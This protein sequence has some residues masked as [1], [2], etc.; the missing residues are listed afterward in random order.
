M[1]NKVDEDHRHLR[2][3]QKGRVPD[4]ISPVVRCEMIS[5]GAADRSFDGVQGADVAGV[6]TLLEVGDSRVFSEVMTGHVGEPFF[7]CE[8]HH[9]GGLRAAGRNRHV[10]EDV[11]ALFGTGF[12]V[13][14]VA[15]VGRGDDD[16]FDIRVAR[17][18]F[19]AGRPSGAEFTGYLLSAFGDNVIHGYQ[20]QVRIRAD[21]PLV[22]SG[23]VAQTDE[24]EVHGC[25]RG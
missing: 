15:R 7:A 23:V 8:P 1:Q 12:E 20:S 24:S 19:N 6:Q 16:A 9:V 21:G 25:T 17:Q 22:V 18:F 14:I 5:R 13:V 4:V 11:F 2:E 10:D 3:G